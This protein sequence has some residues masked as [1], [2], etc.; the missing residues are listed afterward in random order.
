[1]GLHKVAALVEYD[2]TSFRGFQWQKSDRT[3]QS[4]LEA[5]LHKLSGP[6]GR[7]QAASR[8][9]AGVHARGQVAAFW[10]RDDLD[11]TTIVRGM[12]YYLPEDVALKGACGIDADFDVRRRAVSRQYCYTVLNGGTRSPLNE[13]IALRVRHTLDVRRMRAACRL[14][15]G[16][17]DFAAFA[18]SV[19][20]PDSSTVRFMHEAR[21]L[22][23]AEVVEFWMTA[24]AFLRHQVRNTVGLLLRVG[25]GKT[26]V[27]EF[28]ALI[29][30]GRQGAAGP[31]AV[32]R[33]LC[34]VRVSYESPLGFAA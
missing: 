4:E 22:Q 27:E 20:E 10:V 2:G 24:N 9:D 33:G 8:T 25:L 3:V 6:C 19:D 7:V 5:A 14:L 34:L 1:M 30:G 16:V 18:T 11:P 28:G 21:V 31:A 15:Q 17:H 29:D 32:A 23:T 26:S 13:R 12:N